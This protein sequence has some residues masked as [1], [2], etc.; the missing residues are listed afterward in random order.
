MQNSL[1]TGGN[2]DSWREQ[3]KSGVHQDPGERSSDSM[4]D[5]ARPA[6]GCL[7][8]FCGG[9]GRQ[10]PAVETG[11]QP[12]AVL[13]VM[14]CHKSILEIASSPTVELIDSW[15]GLLQA[16]QLT[17]REHSPTHQHTIGLYADNSLIKIFG[18]KN[19][20]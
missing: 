14:C 15:T 1:R 12:A 9:M 10:W 19:E 7:R 6:R 8:V 2:R 18:N 17:R 5:C 4:R 3:T 11:A 20:T 16:K 13:G